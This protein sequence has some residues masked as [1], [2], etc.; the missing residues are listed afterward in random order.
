[1]KIVGTRASGKPYWLM[2]GFVLMF[3]IASLI[4]VGSSASAATGP[5]PLGTAA[6]FA[7][8]AASTVT[9]TGP[10]KINGDLGLSPGTS[11]TGFPPGQVN[12]TV[13]AADA[14]AS[15]AKNDL[16]AAYVDAE[17]RPTTATVAVELGG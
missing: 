12:G 8:L 10:T 17:G 15:Q 9:N 3:A 7:V 1:M 16:D 5:V 2:P 4:G 11:V 14:V 13:H 6:N